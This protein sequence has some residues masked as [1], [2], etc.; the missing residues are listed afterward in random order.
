[1]K[2]YF[3]ISLLFLSSSL[4]HAQRSIN[5]SSIETE[6]YLELVNQRFLLNGD[7]SLEKILYYFGQY[8]G[9]CVNSPQSAWWL[10]ESYKY[11]RWNSSSWQND[12]SYFLTYNQNNLIS[13][14]RIRDWTG[15]Q[16]IDQCRYLYDYDQLLNINNQTFQV[17]SSNSWI[18]SM[19]KKY[20]YN[21]QGLISTITTF[22]WR[23]SDW[24]NW[25]LMTSTYSNGQILQ[26]VYQNWNDSTWE[27]SNRTYYEYHTN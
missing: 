14:R 23:N 22:H 9:N 15:F 3:F 25:E 7:K 6:K 2:K 26:D 20:D 1:M 24:Q 12:S 5:Y 4:L 18:D 27:N 16:W 21:S 17:Y 10:L 13:E 19:M 11:Q 8:Q